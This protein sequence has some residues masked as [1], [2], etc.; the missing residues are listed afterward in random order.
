MDFGACMNYYEILDA[1][2]SLLTKLAGVLVGIEL[3]KYVEWR[4]NAKRLGCDTDFG[5]FL[6]FI[7]R[8]CYKGDL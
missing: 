3:G 6:L 1:L 4:K 2:L 7:R 5:S 8:N